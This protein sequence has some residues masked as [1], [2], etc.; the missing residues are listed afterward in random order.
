M[1]K[2]GE[3]GA[4]VQRDKKTYAIV[5]HV[6][7]GV[8]TPELLRQIAD[9]AEKYG[10]Q[11]LKLTSAARIAMVGINEEDI[12]AVWAELGA[13]PGAAVGPCV[14]SI[15]ACPGTTFCRLG[16]QD[17]LGLGTELDKKYHGYSLPSKFKI[18]VSGCINQCAE[19]CIKDLGFVGKRKGWTVA[20]G[21]MG[22]ARP[23]LAEMLTTEIN[24]E[25]A[26]K[27]TQKIMDFYRANAKKRERLGK[28]IDRV[29]MEELKKAVLEG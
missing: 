14:R 28:L 20:V 25:E 6:P 11:A 17:S 27:L 29:G 8:I 10:V 23:R 13:D 12:D 26:L 16:M 22:G 24:T 19:N 9:T 7:M 18:G 1:L 3:K 21:G 2:D 5:P 15:K 4:V